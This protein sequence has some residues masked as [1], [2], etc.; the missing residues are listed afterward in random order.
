MLIRFGRV[1]VG[2]CRCTYNTKPAYSAGF[3]RLT[4]CTVLLSGGDK[5]SR[6]P[7]LLNAIQAL[8]HLSYIPEI[9][10]RRILRMN[11]IFV[12]RV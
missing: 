12:K 10:T 2:A 6:T 1:Y 3:Y 4:V 11:Y 5:G 8:S 7:D 9:A